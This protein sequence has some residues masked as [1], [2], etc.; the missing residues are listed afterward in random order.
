MLLG[1]AAKSL[2]LWSMKKKQTKSINC[3]PH[4]PKQT[5]KNEILQ[6]CLF[7]QVFPMWTLTDVPIHLS[8]PRHKEA[9]IIIIALFYVWVISSFVLNVSVFKY[10]N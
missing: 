7:P 2:S 1:I 4:P 9:P 10:L 8:I 5:H 6:I 3:P